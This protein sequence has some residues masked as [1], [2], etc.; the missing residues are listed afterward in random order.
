MKL[1]IP[2]EITILPDIVEIIATSGGGPF[3]GEEDPLYD[4]QGF[5]LEDNSHE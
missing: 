4:K 3:N 1:Y 2:I 5:L